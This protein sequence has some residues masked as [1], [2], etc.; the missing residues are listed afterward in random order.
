MQVEV[1]W[2]CPDC[3][4][5]KVTEDRGSYKRSYERYTDYELFKRNRGCTHPKVVCQIC[6]RPLSQHTSL[7]R[8]VGPV[9]WV[10]N[11]VRAVEA[12]G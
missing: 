2:R 3:G 6:G 11:Y 4:V 12:D 5:E 1:L 10:K 9:C 7:E 8:G